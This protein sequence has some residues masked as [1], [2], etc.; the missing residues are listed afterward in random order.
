MVECISIR[1]NYIAVGCKN[2]KIF[3]L[4]DSLEI[5]SVVSLEDEIQNSKNLEQGSECASVRAIDISEDD[6]TMIVGTLGA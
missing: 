5:I 1:K 3:I 4:G 6:K 2:K